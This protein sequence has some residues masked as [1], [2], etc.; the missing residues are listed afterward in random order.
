MHLSICEWTFLEFKKQPVKVASTKLEHIVS[1]IDTVLII[2]SN[3]FGGYPI[4]D[5][6]WFHLLV[7]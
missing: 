7:D 4:Q 6:C 1:L 3:E 2:N 5:L